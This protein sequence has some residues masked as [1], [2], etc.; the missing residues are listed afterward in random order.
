MAHTGFMVDKHRKLTDLEKAQEIVVFPP[1]D[2]S[3][4]NAA[5]FTPLI[6]EASRRSTSSVIA[7]GQGFLTWKCGA[8][9]RARQASTDNG[10]YRP[11]AKRA[12]ANIEGHFA[13]AKFGQPGDSA[14]ESDSRVRGD[15]EQTRRVSV[16]LLAPSR[17]VIMADHRVATTV[18]VVILEVGGR[19]VTD[20][21]GVRGRDRRGGSK[22]PSSRSIKNSQ[23]HCRAPSL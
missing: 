9:I 15:P 5:P 7:L 3:G 6:S 22:P 19:T 4:A 13:A 20:G 2:A 21:F 14:R 18:I 12:S 1:I 16:T 17:V 8:G 10:Q 11:A 23:L